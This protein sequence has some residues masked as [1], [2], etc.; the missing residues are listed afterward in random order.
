MQSRDEIADLRQRVSHLE[1]LV[2][3]LSKQ[4]NLTY[5]PDVDTLN[6]PVIDLLR[7]DRYMEAIKRYR[8]I[9]GVSLAIGTEAVN[10]LKA[11]HKL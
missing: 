11:T 3:S 2:A 5:I 4:L 1:A 6:Q 9:H 7:Q 8:D 10:Q